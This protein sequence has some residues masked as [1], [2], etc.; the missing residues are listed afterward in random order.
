M[1]TVADAARSV[2]GSL[3]G[4][5]PP[6]THADPNLVVS[7]AETRKQQATEYLNQIFGRR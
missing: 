3:P 7:A 1:E 4:I 5:S 6:V 2:N